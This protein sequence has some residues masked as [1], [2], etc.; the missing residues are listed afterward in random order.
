MV[1]FL[2]NQLKCLPYTSLIQSSSKLDIFVVILLSMCLRIH[3]TYLLIITDNL[4]KPSMKNK[5]TVSRPA[6]KDFKATNVSTLNI[7]FHFF[8]TNTAFLRGH[9]P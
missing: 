9:L 8:L 3:F 6:E 4:L 2:L 5:K 1:A 7:L